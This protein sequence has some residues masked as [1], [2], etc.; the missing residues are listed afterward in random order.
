LFKTRTAY[1]NIINDRS[2]PHYSAAISQYDPYVDMSKIDLSYL[3]SYTPIIVDPIYP[4]IPL[5]RPKDPARPSIIRRFLLPLGIA[6]LMPIWVTFFVLVSLYQSFFS[7]WRIRQHFQLKEDLDSI[8]EASLSG[9]VQEAFEDVVDN[10]SLLSPTEEPNEYFE[11]I[12][13]ETALL[14]GDDNAN[15]SKSRK[16]ISFK[17]EE[18]CLALTE[19]QL[20]MMSGLRSLSWQA[21]GVHIHQTRR[22]HAAIIRRR[23]K[24]TEG[25]VVIR[26]WLDRQFQV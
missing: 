14:D 3:P 15:D 23:K 17:R 16:A 1:A 21:F 26:H 5:S 11:S 18:Y 24:P 25:N 19:D 7:A 12:T 2:V 13:E 4:V 9:A 6:L 22:S 10:A 20:A 8:E